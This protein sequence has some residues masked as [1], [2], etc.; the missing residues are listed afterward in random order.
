MLEVA[1]SAAENPQ[2]KP[3]QAQIWVRIM[4]YLSQ[5]I[6]S[7]AE[8]FDE[9]RAIEYL[10]NLERMVNE[11]KGDSDEGEGTGEAVAGATEG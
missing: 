4:A 8:S 1:K 6:N 3:K 2:T 11:A 5:V 10:K 9:A 7:I